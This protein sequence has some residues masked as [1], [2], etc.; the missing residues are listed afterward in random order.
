M[1]TIVYERKPNSVRNSDCANCA[2][3]HHIPALIVMSDNSRPEIISVC[4]IGSK[5]TEK[6]RITA[7]VATFRPRCWDTSGRNASIG[8]SGS[9]K[10]IIVRVT[11]TVYVLPF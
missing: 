2:I 8:R 4:E 10:L 11:T 6:E 7:S 3:G 1:G 9:M 5:L